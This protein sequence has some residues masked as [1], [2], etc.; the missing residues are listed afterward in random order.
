MRTQGQLVSTLATRIV[1]EESFRR[2]SVT[3]ADWPGF[4]L[5]RDTAWGRTL[6]GSAVILSLDGD[7]RSADNN[8]PTKAAVAKTTKAIIEVF[9]ANLTSRVDF[10]RIFMRMYH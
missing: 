9:A 4:R 3:R 5:P 8:R 2:R 7:D 1:V 6:I 10:D